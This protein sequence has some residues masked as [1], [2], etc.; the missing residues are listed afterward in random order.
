MDL[1]AADCVAVRPPAT[2]GFA[3]ARM[4]HEPD[5]A[6]V[7][8]DNRN[9][10]AGLARGGHALEP[11]SHLTVYRRRGDEAMQPLAVRGVEDDGVWGRGRASWQESR[12]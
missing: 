1:A 2:P 8:A 12:R 5:Q 11:G 6:L 9:A 3:G 10:D 7:E 4:E